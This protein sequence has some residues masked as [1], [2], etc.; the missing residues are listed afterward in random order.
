MAIFIIFDFNFWEGQKN[1]VR[2]CW[3]LDT[4]YFRLLWKKSPIKSAH[5]WKWNPE[6]IRPFVSAFYKWALKI[7]AIVRS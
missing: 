1:A 2:G 6:E 7:P 3:T 5:E 4:K